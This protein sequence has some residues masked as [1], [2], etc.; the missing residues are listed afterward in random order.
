MFLFTALHFYYSVSNKRI[1]TLTCAIVTVQCVAVFL[2]MF[3]VPVCS[4]EGRCGVLVV[5]SSRGVVYAFLQCGWCFVTLG[6]FSHFANAPKD[7]SE[8]TKIIVT[9]F[10]G[11]FSHVQKILFLSASITV[12]YTIST[13]RSTIIKRPYMNYC[14][15]H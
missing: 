11:V 3:A 4:L 14:K 1:P 15:R 5:L 12:C 13:I 7:L 6:R 9:Y 2:S 10:D 8:Y